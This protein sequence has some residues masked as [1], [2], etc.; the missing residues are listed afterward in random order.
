MLRRRE[1][2]VDKKCWIG[3]PKMEN[4][5]NPSGKLLETH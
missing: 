2:E 3:L 4:K 1:L 5:Q